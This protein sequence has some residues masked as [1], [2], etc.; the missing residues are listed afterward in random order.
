MKLT[1][2]INKTLDLETNPRNLCKGLGYL[3]LQH[4]LYSQEAHYKNYHSLS[5][6]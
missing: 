1:E 4:Q 6:K 2:L 5:A 3:V